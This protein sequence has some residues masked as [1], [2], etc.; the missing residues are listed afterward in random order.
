MNTRKILY[1]Y[2]MSMVGLPYMWGGDDTING[3]DCSGLVLEA[4]WSQ[5]MGPSGDSTAQG[6]R[7]FYHDYRVDKPQFGDLVF[8]GSKEKATHIGIC[9]NDK[10]FIEAGGG[11]QSTINKEIASKQNAF[12]R[13]RPINKRSDLLGFVMPPW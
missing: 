12:I 2:L 11:G 7:E 1:D 9:L 4:L 5:G 13:I 10:L 3:F 8:Y 6:I